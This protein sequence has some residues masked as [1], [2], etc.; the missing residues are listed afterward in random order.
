M[1]YDNM[2]TNILPPLDSWWGT[3]VVIL[4]VLGF[5]LFLKGIFGLASGERGRKSAGNLIMTM[6]AGILLLNTPLLLDGLAATIFGSVSPSSLSYAAPEHPAR[7]YVQFA[8]HLIAVLG[9]VGVGR[10]IIILKDGASR[11]GELGRA[12][13]HVIGGSL[14]VNLVTTLRFLGNSFGGGMRGVM[15]AILG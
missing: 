12:L 4:R 15:D 11:P 3:I 2:L 6:A 10:G 7:V 5:G 1:P 9:L 8:V 14:C 13:A